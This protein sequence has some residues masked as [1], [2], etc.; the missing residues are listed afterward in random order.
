[1]NSNSLVLL[2]TLVLSTS[3]HNIYKYCK[4][5]K[6]RGRIVGNTIGMGVFYLMLIGYCIATTIGYGQIGIIEVVPLQCALL[7]SLLAFVLTLFKTNGYLF[8]FRE[9]DML[10]SLPFEAKTVAGCKFLYMYIKSLPWY[11]SIAFS[12]LVGYGIYAGPALWI[13]PMW[14]LLSLFLP[15]IPML[16]AAFLGFLIAKIGSGFR[17]TNLIQTILMFALVFLCFGLRFFLESMFRNGQVEETLETISETA[18]RA[19][20]VYFPALWFEKAILDG[21]VSSILLVIG[22]S[23]LLFEILFFLVGRSYR[24]INSRLRSHAAARK[25]TMTTRKRR[26]VVNAIAFKEFK[27]MTGS[28]TYMVNAAMGEVLVFFAGIAVLFLDMDKLLETMLQGAPVTAKM[29]YPAIPFIIYFFLGMVAT[30][31][32]SPSLEGKN[33]WIVQSLPIKPITL[34]HGKMLFHLYLTIPF[35]VFATVCFCISAGTSLFT[36]IL[37]LLLGISLCVFST[38][39]GCVCGI[40]HMRLD[41]E[42][43]VEVIKQ[44]T[45]VSIYLLP[46][47]FATMGL[48]V[49]SVFLGMKMDQNLVLAGMIPVVLLL[50]GLCYRRV[51]ILVID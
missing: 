5:K 12:M 10:M 27:R 40:R 19:G 45:A 20:G 42:N 6:K 33:Y 16:A 3:Q 44:G 34:Y 29:L 25:Y 24:E 39:W 48:V 35:C 31:A 50:A 30:T 17:K 8:Q 15:V 49:L 26:S 4:D 2:R 47:M 21:S 38:C 23:I 14:I 18:S 46:N 7:I 32:F 41:W 1:M 37:C 36:A 11:M 13:Y 51:R 22:L 43:E 9:Y 28:T